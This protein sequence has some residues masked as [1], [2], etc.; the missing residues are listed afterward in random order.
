MAIT[1]KLDPDLETALTRIATERGQSLEELVGET[2]RSYV[3]Y[4]DEFATK[5]PGLVSIEDDAAY[6]AALAEAEAEF[7][8]GLGIPHEKVFAARRSGLMKVDDEAAFIRAVEEGI[9]QADRGETV[10]HEEVMRQLEET[11]RKLGA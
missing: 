5:P 7:D 10:S 8:A 6:T 3:E 1:L 11:L 2:L 9:A 4:W